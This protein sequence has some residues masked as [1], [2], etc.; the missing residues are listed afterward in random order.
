MK[1]SSNGPRPNFKVPNPVPQPLLWVAV[2]QVAAEPPSS[3]S[4]A[5]RFQ[6]TH[7]WP[8][9]KLFALISL[10]ITIPKPVP[11]L[12][13]CWGQPPL[14]RSTPSQSRIA[15]HAEAA[16]KS[17]RDSNLLPWM[18][19]VW[20]ESTGYE[21]NGKNSASFANMLSPNLYPVRIVYLYRNYPLHLCIIP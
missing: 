8:T 12:L 18:S 5:R 21:I 2:H 3:R 9:H 7:G 17:V 1:K 13:N 10:Q 11:D 4:P 19:C 14:N 6:R 16:T 20:C 15:E